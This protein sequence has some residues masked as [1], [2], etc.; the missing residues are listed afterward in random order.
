M[1]NI[2]ETDESKFEEDIAKSNLPVLAFF[3]SEWCPACK[4]ITPIVE[5]ISTQYKDKIKFIRI[6]ATKNI[7][8]SQQ[9]NVLSIPTLILFKNGKEIQRNIG[10]ISENQLK[11]FLNK[12]L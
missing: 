7:K 3:K 4:K 1:S 2:S 9:N 10:Y 8:V 12:N 6:D 5:S 11:D